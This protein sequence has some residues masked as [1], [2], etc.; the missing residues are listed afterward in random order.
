MTA[1]MDTVSYENLIHREKVHGS[2]YTD[3]AIFQAEMET[4][5]HNGWV[6]VGHTSEVP[7]AGDFSRRQIG[8]QPV[9]ITRDRDNNV[10]LLLNRCTHR[11]NLLCNRTNGNASTF[12][13]PYHGWSFGV[14]GEMR[15]MPMLQAMGEGFDKAELGLA[16]VPRVGIHRGFI[17]ASLASEGES[18]EEYL[19]DAKVL[20]DR[21]ADLSP[22]GEV[23]LSAGWLKH[24]FK[25]NWKMLPENNTDGYHVGSTHSSM[26]MATG[27]A[28]SGAFNDEMGDPSVIRD[29]GGGHTELDFAPRYRMSGRPFQWFGGTRKSKLPKYMAAMEA[30]YGK[31]ETEER[32]LAGPPHAIIFPNLFLAELNIT[33]FYPVS[34]NE[35]IQYYTPLL[36]KGAP[37][38]NKRAMRQTEG[39]MGPGSFLLPEDASMAERNQLGLEALTPEWMD[40]RRGLH[41]EHIDEENGLLTSSVS[42][43]TTN[44]AF[45][46]HYLTMMS[47]ASSRAGS[48]C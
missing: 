10:N 28:N 23:D 29:W 47:K 42:D 24:R 21:S 18:F 8:K 6:F 22:E 44:R 36:L 2:L 31:E 41:R 13:C 48:G 37:E 25:A 33:Y 34:T 5:F 43:E 17:F 3:P 19:G 16:H 9:L 27:S 30:A 12:T 26:L 14:D 40:L 11:G 38:V 7:K 1:K 15:G 4:I 46:S 32:V 39:A 35:V 45:W 20:L